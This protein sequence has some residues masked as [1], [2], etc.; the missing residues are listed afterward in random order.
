MCAK[1]TKRV[2]MSALVSAAAALAADALRER[3]MYAWPSLSGNLPTLDIEDAG[4][5]AVGAAGASWN[6]I[7]GNLAPR[8]DKATIDNKTENANSQEEKVANE[9]RPHHDSIGPP[10][11][12][13]LPPLPSAEVGLVSFSGAGAGAETSEAG[14]ASTP[15]SLPFSFDTRFYADCTRARINLLAAQ[16]CALPGE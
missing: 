10:P 9:T 11:S 6:G 12:N 15:T 1:L 3:A 16:K 5:G 14:S 4:L 7:S 8:D 13:P 2:V